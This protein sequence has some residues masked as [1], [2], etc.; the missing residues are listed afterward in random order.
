MTTDSYRAGLPVRKDFLL[1]GNSLA[2][3]LSSGRKKSSFML[4]W[5]RITSWQSRVL[6]QASN[7]FIWVSKIEKN[8]LH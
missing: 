2:C 8:S 1:H 4:L 5:K 3:V 7:H 6:T